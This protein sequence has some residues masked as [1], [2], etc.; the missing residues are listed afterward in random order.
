MHFFVGVVGWGKIE[1]CKSKIKS[2]NVCNMGI[3]LTLGVNSFLW[4]GD[5]VSI[6]RKTRVIVPLSPSSL[7]CLSL[8]NNSSPYHKLHLPSICKV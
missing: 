2:R 3:Y 5:M 8:F 4:G 1:S 7:N 6:S